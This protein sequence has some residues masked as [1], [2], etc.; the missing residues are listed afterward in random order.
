[1]LRLQIGPRW[2]QAPIIH[3]QLFVLILYLQ[4]FVVTLNSD[5]SRKFWDDFQT[6]SKEFTNTSAV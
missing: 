6:K 5:P 4:S 3:I 1:M 2:Q